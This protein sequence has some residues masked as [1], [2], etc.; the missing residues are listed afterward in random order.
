MSSAPYA[1]YLYKDENGKSELR[2]WLTELRRS[3]PKAFTKAGWL[4]ERLEQEGAA[5]VHT[6][7]AKKIRG[8]VYELRAKAG[9][10]PIRI[11]YW[12]QGEDFFLVNGELKQQN[13]PDPTLIER[14][15]TAH[16]KHNDKT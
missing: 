3:N 8:P 10:D 14:A 4:I 15:L 6:V 13:K 16:R 1:V 9:T 11:Y 7:Y 5:L 2:E 12:Q